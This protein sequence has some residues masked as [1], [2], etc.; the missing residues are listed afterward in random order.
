M[1]AL[2]MRRDLN[3]ESSPVQTCLR[4]V[5]INRDRFVSETRHIHQ[6]TILSSQRLLAVLRSA[7]KDIA[8]PMNNSSLVE[9]INLRLVCL[10]LLRKSEFVL[11]T[12][13]HHPFLD[14]GTAGHNC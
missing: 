7:S 5:F 12:A 9:S 10:L 2:M 11:G 13:L 6:Q 3:L 8:P 14:R 1:R 4:A